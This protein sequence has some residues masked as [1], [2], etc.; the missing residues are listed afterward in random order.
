MIYH[1]RGLFWYLGQF[2]RGVQHI[3]GYSLVGAHRVVVHLGVLWLCR[4]LDLLD[5]AYAPIAALG[6]VCKLSSRRDTLFV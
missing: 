3:L 4:F 2:P 5:A 6:R 1:A